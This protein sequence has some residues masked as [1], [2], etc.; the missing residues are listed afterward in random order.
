VAEV[1]GNFPSVLAQGCERFNVSAVLLRR[2]LRWVAELPPDIRESLLE[3]MRRD[4]DPLQKFPTARG[5][6]RPRDGESTLA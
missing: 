4:V 6:L 1:N 3:A 5:W 2:V